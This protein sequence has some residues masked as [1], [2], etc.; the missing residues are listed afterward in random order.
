MTQ[1]PL[2][3]CTL[4]AFYFMSVTL[5]R[6]SS[7]P[8]HSF[9]HG[10]GIGI[11]KL[12]YWNRQIFGE[13]SLRSTVIRTTPLYHCFLV[14]NLAYESI[15]LF[16]FCFVLFLAGETTCK[17]CKK[18]HVLARW[19]YS[20]LTTWPF[21]TGKDNKMHLTVNSVG[22]LQI[23]SPPCCKKWPRPLNRG[24]VCSN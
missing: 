12:E 21:N 24:H 13:G 16:L 10:Y 15:Q 3:S 23:R 20:S 2:P 7:F 18:Q 9:V 8:G 19:L 17:G 22:T 6:C 14:A 11:E 5:F 1:Q 4:R